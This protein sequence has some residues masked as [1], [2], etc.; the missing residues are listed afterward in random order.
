MAPQSAC[1]NTL[2]HAFACTIGVRQRQKAEALAMLGESLATLRPPGEQSGAG[3]PEN[4]DARA[5]LPTGRR[6]KR[7]GG[8]SHDDDR[9]LP[10]EC[11]S[12][13]SS[14]TGPWDVTDV[15][16]IVVRPR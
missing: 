9:E 11:N 1:R 6:N 3:G 13:E 4:A 2:H 10:T 16:R 8:C 15:R 12:V 14:G 7:Q 5:R